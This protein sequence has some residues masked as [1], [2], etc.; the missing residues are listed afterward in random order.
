[1]AKTN[2]TPIRVRLAEKDS[3]AD[4]DVQIAYSFTT[5][6][7]DTLSRTRDDVFGSLS[8]PQKQAVKDL[9]VS[10]RQRI[11]NVENIG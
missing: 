7:G 4:P 3:G 2:L 1:M 9:L 11:T 5:S 10:L 6:D 8:A